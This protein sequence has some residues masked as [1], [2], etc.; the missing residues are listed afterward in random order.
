MSSEGV[1]Q[2]VA[3][4]FFRVEP[5]WRRLPIEERVAH[6]EAFAEVVDAWAERMDALRAYSLT[7]VRPEESIELRSQ[8]TDAH[9]LENSMD[10]ATSAGFKKLSPASVRWLRPTEWCGRCLT[11]LLGHRLEP[12]DDGGSGRLSGV[13]AAANN[14]R[15]TGSTVIR[16]P[17]CG[18]RWCWLRSRAPRISRWLLP[19][20]PA[21]TRGYFVLD[22]RA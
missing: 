14:A 11:E 15:Q 2:Y 16:P 4:T 7:G 8:S 13:S 20:N 1:G 5:E 17:R 6:K 19:S 18:A 9:N 3:Y 12:P 22:A 10:E 21:F